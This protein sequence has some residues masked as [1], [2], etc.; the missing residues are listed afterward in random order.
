MANGADRV[1]RKKLS[2]IQTRGYNFPVQS[3]LAAKLEFAAAK[4]TTEA[5]GVPVDAMVEQSQVNR[6]A[7]LTDALTVPG[8]FVL[9]ATPSRQRGLV[10][11]DA[12]LVDHVVEILAGGNPH[13][14]QTNQP[15]VPTAIDTAFCLPVIGAISGHYHSELSAFA[16]S[17]QLERFGI[18]RVE[19]VPA[20]LPLLL[21]DQQYLCCRV[22]LDI[23]N[24]GR[25]GVMHFAAPLSWFEPIE[26][27]LSKS[28][29]SP[30]ETESELWVQRM[31]KVVRNAPLHVTAEIDRCR[32][33]VAELTRLQAGGLYPLG[34]ATLDNVVL[35]L[36][37]GGERRPIGRGRLGAYKRCK[38][39]RL[40]EIA[41]GAFLEPLARTLDLEDI[42]D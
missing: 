38:A 29:V 24:D 16:G 17:T 14:A 3:K 2:R 6:L 11:F 28:S 1:L 34:D 13:A 33:N 21:L 37:A 18:D 8:L 4:G 25:T 41:D 40:H 31:R 9:L 42:D 22:K 30:A 15:R 10:A 36:D 35:M 32:M 26:T 12:T 7:S 39:I 20:N 19:Q 27:V 5:L 23:G